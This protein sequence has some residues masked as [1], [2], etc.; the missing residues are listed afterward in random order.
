MPSDALEDLES[1]ESLEL[2]SVYTKD[3][4]TK[5]LPRAKRLTKFFAAL[6]VSNICYNI[7]RTTEEHG[8]TLRFPRTSKLSRSQ[9]IL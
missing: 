5:D 3:F 8:L 9:T 1:H 4:E 7:V 6:N 2:D